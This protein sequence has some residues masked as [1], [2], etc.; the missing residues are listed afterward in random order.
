VASVPVVIDEL[1]VAETEGVGDPEDLNAGVGVGVGTAATG[2]A[3][4]AVRCSST[5]ASA[6]ASSRQTTASTM[7]DRGT[8]RRAWG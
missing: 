1:G 6:I 8:P 4:G 7:V 5:T 3:V 2:P